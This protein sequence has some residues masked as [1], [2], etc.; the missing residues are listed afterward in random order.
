MKGLHAQAGSL[1]ATSNLYVDRRKSQ[2]SGGN[3]MIKE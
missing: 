1:A 2:S 3:S